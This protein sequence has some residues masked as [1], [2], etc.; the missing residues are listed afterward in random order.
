M[1]TG[2]F[3][4]GP[5]RIRQLPRL[6]ILDSDQTVR[7][8]TVGDAFFLRIPNQLGS[9]PESDVAQMRQGGDMM[10]ELG[11]EHRALAR[12]DA[13]EKVAHMRGMG[14]AAAGTLE[15]FEIALAPFD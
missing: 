8:R 11:I 13:V 4:L 1:H 2:A 10:S 5:L 15:R 6:A 7:C 14:V 12:A 9:G 3:G